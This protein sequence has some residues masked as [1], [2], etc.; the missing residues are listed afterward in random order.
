MNNIFTICSLL[1][2]DDIKT[3]YKY[4]QR[5]IKSKCDTP[6]CS[7]SITILDIEYDIHDLYQHIN[8]IEYLIFADIKENGGLGVYM[9][10]LKSDTH[11]TEA[12]QDLIYNK[13]FEMVI[14]DKEINNP[15]CNCCLTESNN[16]PSNSNWMTSSVEFKEIFIDNKSNHYT[17]HN[18]LHICNSC[19]I[20]LQLK[21]KKYYNSLKLI[22]MTRYEFNKQTAGFMRFQ[23]LIFNLLFNYNIKEIRETLG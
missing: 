13:L 19:N 4:I 11:I 12:E 22:P 6:M 16:D 14:V 15:L 8:N 20:L 21:L 1:D 18:Y 3:N 2:T 17:S 7:S 10:I 5:C 23:S 9:N